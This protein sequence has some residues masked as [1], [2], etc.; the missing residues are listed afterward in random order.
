VLSV[1]C[2]LFS[3]F[4]LYRYLLPEDL[5]ISGVSLGYLLILLFSY[6]PALFGL[7]IG[8]NHAHSLLLVTFLAIF[9]IKKN[10]GWAGLCAALL[11]YKPQMLVG[12]LLLWLLLKYYKALL[13]FF[14]VGGTWVGLTLLHKGISPYL[15]Y[16]QFIPKTPVF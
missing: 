9:T 4:L 11:L 5:K 6:Y 3:S 8:Q 13:V 2:L 12:W 10:P 15:D 16:L 1:S 7:Q 14:L